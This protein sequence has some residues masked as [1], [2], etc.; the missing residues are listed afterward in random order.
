MYTGQKIKDIAS[1]CRVQTSSIVATSRAKLKPNLVHEGQ[2]RTEAQ[3]RLQT[4]G[5]NRSLPL[6]ST[7]ELRPPIGFH[8]NLLGFLRADTLGFRADMKPS[9][10]HE[11]ANQI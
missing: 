8:E 5:L 1:S 11:K 10:V 3:P 9:P 4:A 6:K 2:H 7:N